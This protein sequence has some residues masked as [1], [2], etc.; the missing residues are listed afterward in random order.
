MN[1][2]QT[3]QQRPRGKLWL[4][5]IILQSLGLICTIMASPTFLAQL[6]ST[7]SSLSA[8]G[9]ADSFDQ[10]R[11]ISWLYLGL[12]VF[13]IIA[14]IGIW[15]SATW[16]E[17]YFVAKLSILIFLILSVF[18]FRADYSLLYIYLPLVLSLSYLLLAYDRI[19]NKRRLGG[20]Q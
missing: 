11:L 14:I 18:V 5:V 4:S 3:F 2:Q 6:G 13:N 7:H 9:L 19:Q 15:R 12:L 16:I 20:R 17:S 8:Y 1:H 10:S